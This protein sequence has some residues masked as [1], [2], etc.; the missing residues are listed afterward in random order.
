MVGSF[1]NV[2]PFFAGTLVTANFAADAFIKDLSTSARQ[3]LQ[4]GSFQSC[5]SFFDR[6][7]RFVE[8]VGQFDSRESL[9]VKFGPVRLDLAKHTFKK[10]K[11]HFGMYTAN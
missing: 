11:I 2:Q 8:H 4:T 9:N 7:F 5:Q 1:M 6:Y 10:S 3:R